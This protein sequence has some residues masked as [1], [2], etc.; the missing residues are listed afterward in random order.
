MW[1]SIVKDFQAMGSS[2]QIVIYVQNKAN[3]QDIIQLCLEIIRHLEVKYSRYIVG[4]C[5]YEINQAA[6]QGHKISLDS[7]TTALINYAD[8]CYN[9]SEGLFDISSGVLRQAWNFKTP[10]LPTASKIKQLLNQI[11]WEKITWDKSVLS[12]GATGMELD[13]GGI[14]KEYAADQIA[15]MCQNNGILHGLINLGGDIRII[16]AQPNNKSWLIGIKDPRNKGKNIATLALKQG[17]ISSSGDY[18]RSY[19]LANKYYSHILNPK[20]GYPVTGLASV[21]VIADFC[22]VAG[23]ASTIAMLY[24][25]QGGS[26]LQENNFQAIWVDI[27]GNTNN[28][29]I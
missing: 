25:H 8:A 17:G 11:G 27:Y 24:Q 14:V 20:T 7:E 26:W 19:I 10:K 28:S 21:T 18:E 29:I 9:N 23:S 2:C 1:H 13:F 6:K 15:T 5:L 3:A 22:L 12:F 16:G 4:N